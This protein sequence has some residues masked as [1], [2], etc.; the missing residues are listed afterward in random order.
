[1]FGLIVLLVSF[2]GL[3]LSFVLFWLILVY[4]LYFGLCVLD[5]ALFVD[6]FIALV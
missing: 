2:V 3:C 6:L 1:M 5:V 4:L